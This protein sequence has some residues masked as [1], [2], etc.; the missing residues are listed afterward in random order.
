[1]IN[2]K[3]EN[4]RKSATKFMMIQWSRFSNVKINLSG[5]TLITGVNGSGK[6]TILDAMLYMLTG[7]TQ[8]NKA[9]KD[10]DRSIISYVRGDTKSNGEERFLRS[11]KVITYLAME[12]YS[13]IEQCDFVVGVCIESPNESQSKSYWFV[14]RDSQIEDFNFY[15]IDGKQLIVT[16]KSELFV[17]GVKF[18][19]SEFMTREKG[20]EQILRALGLR[21]DVNK[22][23]TKLL[24]ML[25]F[26]P[27][28]NI[29]KFIQESVLEPNPINSL[30]Q[31]KEYKEQLDKIQKLYKEL[32]VGREKLKKIEEVT[33]DYEKRKDE[34]ELQ[35]ILFAYQNV[36]TLLEKQ[37]A[38]EEKKQSAL[39]QKDDLKKRI[40]Q[41]QSSYEEKEKNINEIK[42]NKE[43]KDINRNLEIIKREKEAKENQIKKCEE[44]LA[45]IKRNEIKIANIL[46]WFEEESDFSI[47]EKDILLRLSDE[48][49][50]EKKKISA[51]IKW[52]ERISKAKEWYV[53]Q[54]FYCKDDKRKLENDI[55][56]KEDNIK[57]LEAEKFPLEKEVEEAKEKIQM[58]FRKKGIEIDVRTFAELVKEVTD[59]SWRKPLEVFLG[60]KRFHLIVDGE[61]C[62]QALEVVEKYKLKKVHLVL[63]DR[64]PDTKIVSGSAAQLLDVPNIYARRYANYLLNGI[65]LC[66]N[67]QELHDYPKGGIMRNGMLAKSYAS[68]CMNIDKVDYYL[69]SDSKKLQLKKAKQEKEILISKK[70]TI[71]SQ[72]EKLERHI[73]ELEEN[74]SNVNSYHFQEAFSIE[75]YRKEKIELENRIKR[76]EEDPKLLLFLDEIKRL[77]EELKEIKKLNDKGNQEIGSLKTTIENCES[78]LKD[79]SG[80]LY[81]AE[82]NFEEIADK[83]LSLKERAIKKYEELVEKEQSS[84]VLK[85]SSIKKQEKKIQDII[86]KIEDLHIEYCEIVNK[87]KTYRGVA[88]ISLYREEYQKVAN[89]KVEEAKQRLKDQSKKLESA[90]MNDFV[91]EINEMIQQAKGEI[92][93]IN[94]ELRNIPFGNDTYCFKMKERGDR[95]IFFK[96]AKRLKDYMEAPILLINGNQ[97]DEELENDIKQFMNLILEEDDETEYTDYRKYFHYDMEIVTKQGEKSISADLSKK[98]GSAS[99]GEKQTPY[100]IIL[101]ASLL[102]CYPR[103]ICCARLA[104]I[105]EAFSALSRERIEKLVQYFEDNGFQVIYA[106]PPEKISSIGTF[107]TS[108]VSLIET[109]RYT[110]AVEGLVDV[111][112]YKS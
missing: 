40:E 6:S 104:F 18:S 48:N 94:R 20:T 12:F 72:Y 38:I 99:N 56:E 89:V 10:Q 27:E 7:N 58:E 82:E 86:S 17:K 69:G 39:I 93:A 44:E 26:N 74:P 73:K 98:Q 88:Y 3:S 103:N 30:T 87:E 100:F 55:S 66:E 22:Y 75:K 90:F 13:P 28:N 68:S 32:L 34:I 85:E 31:L 57:K 46:K 84:Y 91:A 76:L 5:S 41:L 62:Y 2:I 35:R 78:H 14:K 77:E 70:K 36:K 9:A 79:I 47:E 16:P 64:L 81:T 4:S 19:T 95:E 52:N 53:E 50:D 59:Q 42:N 106:A 108:T 1:M 109:G 23:R 60:N 11:G 61:Y 51:L 25:A 49:V 63:T 71:Q 101:A 83:N 67:L 110:S 80:D 112:Q 24:K 92:D 15:K 96:I 97:D 107:I 37:K 21:C 43:I 105:D 33:L 65:H 45:N 8:F 54:K 29:D 111:E 102:Q